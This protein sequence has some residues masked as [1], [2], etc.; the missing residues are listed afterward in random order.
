M[1]VLVQGMHSFVWERAG[2]KSVCTHI[3]VSVWLP[4]WSRF[5]PL[6]LSSLLFGQGVKRKCV[7][8]W[9]VC[10]FSRRAPVIG[11]PK[12]VE[13]T[14]ITVQ[15]KG[16]YPRI[17]T[18]EFQW[19]CLFNVTLLSLLSNPFMYISWYTPLISSLVRKIAP[20]VDEK[21]SDDDNYKAAVHL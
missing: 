21:V 20:E 5:R 13:G 11:V 2:S 17:Y 3:P 6:F 18:L 19:D 1:P 15:Y 12:E 16:I 4:P 14:W 7:I 9:F 10:V 8:L